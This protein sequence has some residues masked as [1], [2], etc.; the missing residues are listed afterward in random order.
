MSSRPV[1]QPPADLVVDLERDLAPGEAD[2]L[3]A[4]VDL[5][6]ARARRARWQSSSESTTGSSPIFVQLE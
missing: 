2:L 6:L 4:Q 3:L 5:A 1:E